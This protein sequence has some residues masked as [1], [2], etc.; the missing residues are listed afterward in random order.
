MKIK[1]KEY[2]G[3]KYAVMFA[4]RGHWGDMK[5]CF[6]TECDNGFDGG[7]SPNIGNVVEAIE[8][9]IDKWLD[10]PIKSESQALDALDDCMVW[11]GYENCHIDRDKALVV[12]RSFATQQNKP[13][14]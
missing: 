9:A 7:H 14:E 13:E 10:T 3:I 2:R 11:T 8:K 1:D 4:D 5:D 12:L 6:Y